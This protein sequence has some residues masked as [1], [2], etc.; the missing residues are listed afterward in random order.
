MLRKMIT[1]QVFLI[2]NIKGPMK[3]K[4]LNSKELLESI[5]TPN[6]GACGYIKPLSENLISVISN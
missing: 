6:N 3:I 5:K 2:F 1:A 4:S